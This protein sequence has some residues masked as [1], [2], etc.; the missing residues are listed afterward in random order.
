MAHDVFIS[1]SN[2][3]KATADAVCATL[4]KNGI[5]CWIAPRD[6]LPSETWAGAIIEA[7]GNSRLFVLIFSAAANAS[8]QVTREVE[9][10]VHAGIPI[11]PFRVEDVTPS[12]DMSYFLST[13]H[14]LDAMTPPLAAHLTRLIEISS[15]LLKKQP[16][17]DQCNEGFKIKEDQAT[18]FLR[19]AQRKLAI[20]RR[21]AEADPSNSDRQRDVYDLCVEIGG[22]YKEQGNS[23]D[24]MDAYLSA[25]DI[26]QRLVAADPSNTTLQQ[27]LANAHRYVGQ[28][29]STTGQPERAV[30]EH[31]AAQAILVH[32]AEAAPSDPFL[33]IQLSYTHCDLGDAQRQLGHLSSAKEAYQAAQCVVERLAGAYPR[34]IGYLRVV[35]VCRSNLGQA[36]QS[37]S[38]TAGALEEYRAAYAIAERL[39]SADPS[40]TDAQRDLWVYGWNTAHALDRLGDDRAVEWFERARQAL[41]NLKST[42]VVLS[43]SEEQS[44]QWLRKKLGKE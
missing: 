30:E 21:L 10:A 25:L 38:D 28:I 2:H 17:R 22:R 1:Y 33:L 20:A 44:Y 34:Y 4:E 39:S 3:N 5:R 14:W 7:I 6:V 16:P 9:R 36:M 37:R 43:D 18:I 15:L 26:I 40:V 13:T 41:S 11:V 12:K 35:S 27:S 24:A 31:Q 29:L 19:T 23:L 32:L 42:G 8:P